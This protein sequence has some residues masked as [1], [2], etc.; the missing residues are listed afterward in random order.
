PQSPFVKGG[1]SF[2]SVSPRPAYSKSIARHRKKGLL[3]L[4]LFPDIRPYAEHR[5]TVDEIHTLYVEES[6][7]PNGIPVLV[8]HGGPGAGCQ[9]YLRR[10]FDAERFRI[11][12][13]DQRGAGRSTP[14]A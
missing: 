13:F 8:V 3:M 7:N 4:T 6:G 1:S 12:L 2:S 5:L 14:L 9:D 10:F 11:V